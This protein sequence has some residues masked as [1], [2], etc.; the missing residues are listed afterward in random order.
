MKFVSVPFEKALSNLIEERR[1]RVHQMEQW[2]KELLDTWQ[3]LPQPE[4]KKVRKETFQVLEG[5]RQVSVKATE[6]LGESSQSLLMVLSDKDL[7]W[8]YNS[9]FFD[10]LES[11]AGKRKLDVRL[12]TNYSPTSTYVLDEVDL[13][14]GDFAYKDL[15]DAPCFI[16]SDDGQMLLLMEKE[17]ESQ[18][19]PFAMWTNYRTLLQ[20][21][22][23][24]FD[25]MWREPSQKTK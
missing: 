24:L 22:G 16:M 1:Q 23:M 12:M 9:P 13:G 15:R 4:K 20:S 6:L 7:L 8:L 18:D 17:E 14:E 21:Y 3:S 5:R 19:K 25:L 10:D 11:R 2:K